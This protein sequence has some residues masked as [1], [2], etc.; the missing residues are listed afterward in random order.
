MEARKK[1]EGRIEAH[2]RK[3][4][5]QAIV[6]SMQRINEVIRG[7]EESE[8]DRVGK[9]EKVRR[10]AY[11]EIGASSMFVISMQPKVKEAIERLKAIQT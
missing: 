6:D 4:G 1:V 5:E 10:E 8:G 11:S 9:V 3:W 7:L 2:M